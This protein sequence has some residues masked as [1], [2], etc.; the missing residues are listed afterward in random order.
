MS[1]RKNVLLAMALCAS[2]ALAGCETMDQAMTSVR[3]SFDNI[4]WPSFRTSGGVEEV[5]ALAPCPPVSVIE[6]LRSLNQ[7]MDERTPS[8]ANTVSIMTIA[9]VD[10]EC[11]TKDGNLVVDLTLNFQG[12]LGPKARDWR[13]DRP[14]FAYPY[15]VAITRPDGTI[16]TKEMFAATAAYAPGQS[17]VAQQEKIHHVIP[18]QG[19]DYAGAYEI[20]VG[21]QLTDAELAYNRS[22]TA[23]AAP[24]VGRAKLMEPVY[25]TTPREPV[26][27]VKTKKPKKPPVPGVKPVTSPV[28]TSQPVSPSESET[29]PAPAVSSAPAP[30]TESPSAPVPAAPVAASAP[31]AAP[32]VAPAAPAPVAA[33]VTTPPMTPPVTAVPPPSSAPAVVTVPPGEELP[34]DMEDLLAP[35]EDITAPPSPAAAPAPAKPN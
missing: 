33:P 9:G 6:E 31:A 32:V 34:P 7:F 23:S 1:C 20:L 8:P 35:P 15:F 22:L 29:A 27:A 13:M 21:F 11:Q 10:S 17:R 24:A 26:A 19:G 28:A 4:D 18:M 14:S 16:V 25:D 2:L 3:S 30:V 5:A 12:E